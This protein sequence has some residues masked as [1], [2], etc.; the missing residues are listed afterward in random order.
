A[1]ALHVPVVLVLKTV[2]LIALALAFGVARPAAIRTGFY[3]SQVGEFAFVLLGAAAVTGLVS[4]EGNTLAMLLVAISMILT[5]LMMKAGDRLAS[6][7]GAEER[8]PEAAASELDH[9]VVIVGFEQVGQLICL[10]LEKAKIPY[11]AFD[12]DIDPVRKGKWWGKNVQFGDIY[13]PVVQEAAALGKADAVYLSSR[14]SERATGLAV[15]LHQL[16]PTLDVFVRAHSLREQGELIDKGIQYAGTDYIESTLV[17]GSELLK[18][19]GVSPGEVVEVVESFRS[20]HY[21]LVQAAS[22]EAGAQPKG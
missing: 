17:R 14:D 6:R 19:L 5:P 18:Q 8:A 22:A 2:V 7:Y 4:S 20:D 11:I 13:N 15:T 3:M 16:Y 10:M 9:H 21:A 12:K 1:L